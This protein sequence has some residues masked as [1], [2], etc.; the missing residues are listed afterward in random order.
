[1]ISKSAF[2][3][4]IQCYKYL[5]LYKFRHELLP[6]NVSESLQRIFD[7]GFEVE[8]YA[9]RLF[10]DG[11]KA[12]GLNKDALRNTKRLIADGHAVIFQAT[13]S[14]ASLFAMSDI[15]VKNGTVWDLRS[16]EFD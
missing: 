8:A 11:V 13:A 15:F 1:M 4:Y 5:W 14:S 9:Y 12:E 10:P 2:L 3:K 6:E 16:E 7:E